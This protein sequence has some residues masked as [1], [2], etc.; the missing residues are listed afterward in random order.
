[1]TGALRAAPP[2]GPLRAG[3]PRDRL[4][5]AATELFCRHGIHAVGVDAVVA[6]AGTAKATL[7]KLFGSKERLVE[8]V[9]E[10]EGRAW[11][12]WFLGGLEAGEAPARERL[13]RIFPLLGTWFRDERFYGCP[14]I[15][16]VGEHD[17]RDDRIRALTL[18]HK[19]QVI[20]RL[21]DLLAEA[22]ARDPDSLVHEVGLLIDGAIVTALVTRD[23]EVGR[24]GA[25]AL[26]SLLDGALPARE[27]RAAA[28]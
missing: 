6:A 26:A 10:Q 23:P 19:R 11:R 12:D 14:F 17:K 16:A 24:V 4:L 13:E 2:A 1:M 3:T 8:T 5:R 7:Y 15:N 28:V 22:G 21:R 9:L 18:A 27:R 20:A 25:R